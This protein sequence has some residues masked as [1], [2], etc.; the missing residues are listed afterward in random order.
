MELELTYD[1]ADAIPEGM[2]DL[3]T[4]RDG[5]WHFTAIPGI[6]TQADVDKVTGALNAEKTRRAELGRAV[7][8]WRKLGETPEAVR[9]QL[10]RIGELEVAANGRLDDKAIEE[11]AKKRADARVAPIQRRLDEAMA[12]R[13]E[14]RTSNAALKKDGRTR[15]V[16]DSLRTAVIDAGI[17]KW[18]HDDAL[19]WGTGVFDVTDEG[20]VQTADGRGVPAG[21]SPTEFYAWVQQDNLRPGWFGSNSGGGAGGGKV[22]TG[23]VGGGPNPWAKDTWNRTQQRAIRKEHGDKVAEAMAKKVGSSLEAISPPEKS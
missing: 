21:M 11:M 12:E 4:E 16:R 19:R 22:R 14:L 1:D 10:D 15:D 17:E 23:T 9:S 8:D 3:Y 2:A 6:K 13:D 5:A 20:V 18:A 7:D